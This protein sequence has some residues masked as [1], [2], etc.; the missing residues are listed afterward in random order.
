M[1]THSY[2]ALSL[3]QTWELSPELEPLAILSIPGGLARFLWEL[4]KAHRKCLNL[5]ERGVQVRS[6]RC[7][8]RRSNRDGAGLG[9]LK[10]KRWGVERP[11]EKTHFQENGE[12]WTPWAGSPR[13]P[14]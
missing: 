12:M 14:D 1:G 7:L 6:E 9:R 2:A 10:G 11:E 5:P 4:P 13:D 8:E 3:Q